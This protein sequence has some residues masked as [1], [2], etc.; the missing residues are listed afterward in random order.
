MKVA[1]LTLSVGYWMGD[2]PRHSDALTREFNG[3]PTFRWITPSDV[4]QKLRV[5][6]LL[7]TGVATTTYSLHTRNLHI[8][9]TWNWYPDFVHHASPVQ[10][11]LARDSSMRPACSGE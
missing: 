5:P 11:V 8:A 10:L 1:L 9:V 6:V 4:E 2:Q 7:L 3:G